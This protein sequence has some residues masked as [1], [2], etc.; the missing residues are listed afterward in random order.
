M[1]VLLKRP[2]PPCNPFSY[3]PVS[4]L[5]PEKNFILEETVANSP[6]TAKNQHPKSAEALVGLRSDLAKFYR[7]NQ[8]LRAINGISAGN[9]APRTAE[10]LNAILRRQGIG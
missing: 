2:T 1:N 3:K 10:Q 5:S 8:K 9:D 7:I 4:K 6:E